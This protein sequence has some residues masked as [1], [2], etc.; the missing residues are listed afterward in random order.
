M[1]NIIACLY[2]DRN[3]PVDRENM[4]MRCKQGR[5]SLEL[6]PQGSERDWNPEHKWF[7]FWRRSMTDI[8]PSNG[9]KAEE[10]YRHKCIGT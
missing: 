6:C 10:W 3:D 7:S 9:E 2:V 1:V 5:Q 4:M 8:T